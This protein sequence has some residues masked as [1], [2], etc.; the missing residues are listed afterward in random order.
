LRLHHA[1]KLLAS[2][3]PVTRVAADCGY[4]SPSAFIESFRQAFGTTPGRYQSD[5]TA[6]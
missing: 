1:L 3:T 5:A 6:R 2:G 4:R